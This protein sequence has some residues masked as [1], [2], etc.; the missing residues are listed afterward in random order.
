MRLFLKDLRIVRAALCF[1]A[2]TCRDPDEKNE[3]RELRRHLEGVAALDDESEAGFVDIT[4]DEVCRALEGSADRIELALRTYWRAWSELARAAASR[5][6]V[7][8]QAMFEECGNAYET[9]AEIREAVG[10]VTDKLRHAS[11]HV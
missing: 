4:S 10:F 9:A 8:P 2:D 3:W 11:M 6:G 5:K 7:L 1:M